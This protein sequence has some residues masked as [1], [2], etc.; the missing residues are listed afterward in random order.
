MINILLFTMFVWDS[1]AFS[2]Y[3]DGTEGM[4]PT[5]ADLLICS[6]KSSVHVI[7]YNK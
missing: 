5:V 1:V 3:V 7:A 4:L 2:G 6:T